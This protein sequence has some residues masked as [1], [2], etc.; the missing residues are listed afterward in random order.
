MKQETF[1]DLQLG[2]SQNLESALDDY[3]SEQ[4]LI[5][6]NMYYTELYGKQVAQKSKKLFYAGVR[7]LELPPILMIQLKR[8]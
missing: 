7:I 2:L 5:D 8:F 6:D 1:I 4:W 3:V